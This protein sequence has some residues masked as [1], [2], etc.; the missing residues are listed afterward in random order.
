VRMSLDIQRVCAICFDID[1]TLS[2]TDDQVVQKVVSVLS[3]V[4]RV[5]PGLTLDKATRKLLMA[6]ETP[7]NWVYS[8]PDVIGL[9][10][11]LA[12]IGEKIIR[13]NHKPLEFL[14]IPGV[15]R[16]LQNLQPL[17]PLA[18]ISA[19]D[20]LGSI[21]F[22][23][24]F[25]IRHFFSFI[26]TAQTCRRTKPYPDPILHAAA[27]FNLRPDQL[28][29]VGDT[30]VDIAAARKAGAQSVGVLCGFGE[31]RELI[32]AGANLILPSTADLLQVIRHPAET[33]IY[34]GIN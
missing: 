6:I 9:D 21:A 32:R 16:L 4:K 3:P 17:Y 25:D 18:V 1:G 30:T 28:L 31:E 14:L 27:L 34:P 8:L 20:H 11:E 2:D 22:L 15:E 19:R 33:G 29:M 10:D 5:F 12:W 26:I 7:G 13:L 24:Q 23:D